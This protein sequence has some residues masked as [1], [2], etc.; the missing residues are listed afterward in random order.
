MNDTQDSRIPT[1]FQD[2]APCQKSLWSWVSALTIRSFQYHKIVWKYDDPCNVLQWCC[3]VEA[4]VIEIEIAMGLSIKQS[5]YDHCKECWVGILSVLS[6]ETRIAYEPTALIWVIWDWMRMT[7]ITVNG[8]RDCSAY[9]HNPMCLDNCKLWN[10]TLQVGLL[11]SQIKPLGLQ[12]FWARL[13][14]HVSEKKCSAEQITKHPSEIHLYVRSQPMQGTISEAQSKAV[15]FFC[16]A[17]HLHSSYKWV[18]DNNCNLQSVTTVANYMLLL[19]SQ[20]FCNFMSQQYS[21]IARL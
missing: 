14:E 5:I 17:V 8:D 15:H 4:S 12:V 6:Q 9:L 10:C 3:I 19:S 18:D 7:G 20:R 13:S 16:F 21:K 11:Q 2:T 1:I